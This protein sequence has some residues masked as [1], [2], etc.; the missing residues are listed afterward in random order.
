MK[1]LADVNI[2]QT[3]ISSLIS[4]GHDVLD[5]KKDDIRATDIQIIK[6]AKA[7]KRII[8]TKDKD[9]IVL[10]QFPKYHT[11]TI[12]IRLKIQEP[13]YILERLIELINHQK[14]NILKKSLTIVTEKSA[15]S[16][17]F[18]EVTPK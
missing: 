9:F 11:A 7:E 14:E 16:Y 8:L 6:L 12:V 3:V 17:S 13:K 15:D 10:T 18:I 1:F 2:P 4:H 5:A